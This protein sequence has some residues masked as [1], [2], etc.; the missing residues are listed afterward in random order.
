METNLLV[1][2][3]L[4]IVVVALTLLLSGL[5]G[6]DVFQKIDIVKGLMGW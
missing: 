3:V 1:F 6:G 4:L 2:F 5:L